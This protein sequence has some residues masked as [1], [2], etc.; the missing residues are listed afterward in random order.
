MSPTSSIARLKPRLQSIFGQL[1]ADEDA[2]IRPILAQTDQL[3]LDLAK[4]FSSNHAG[5][6][7]TG[8]ELVWSPA[9]QI[10]ISSFVEA[11]LDGDHIV[12]FCVSL[13]PGWSYIDFPAELFWQI[14]AWIYAD[15]QHKANH[16]CMHPV[17]RF[18]ELIRKTSIDSVLALL[19]ITEQ[20]V[21]LGKEKPIEY[22]LKLAG[23]DDSE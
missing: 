6:E 11:G 8:L 22:W 23:D 5:W 18:P 3:L 4:H 1:T 19:D 9:G 14:E 15:C 21:Q 2:K 17:H 12:D 20:L 13:N 10:D 16:R 7:G